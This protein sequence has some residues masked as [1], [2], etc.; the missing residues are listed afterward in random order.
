MSLVHELSS[1][2]NA[3][4]ASFASHVSDSCEEK[5]RDKNRREKKK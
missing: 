2:G 4:N 5:R 1:N 3:F